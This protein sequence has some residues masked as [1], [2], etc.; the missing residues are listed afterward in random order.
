MTK[1]VHLTMRST[2]E[3]WCF[4]SIRAIYD[5]IDESEIGINYNS[6][7]NVLGATKP[8][9]RNKNVEIEIKELLRHK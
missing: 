9:F 1:V 7:R 3:S 5:Y 8:F 6:L 2:G 4:G